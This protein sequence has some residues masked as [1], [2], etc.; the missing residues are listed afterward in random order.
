MASLPTNFYYE[1][2]SEL[3][4]LHFERT[5]F[6]RRSLEILFFLEV[7]KEELIEKK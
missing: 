1:Q 6:V 5:V 4:N 7:A 2:M 3:V